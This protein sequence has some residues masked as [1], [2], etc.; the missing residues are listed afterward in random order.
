MGRALSQEL[1]NSPLR[2]KHHEKDRSQ[3]HPGRIDLVRVRLRPYPSQSRYRTIAD[4]LAEPL[5]G[6]IGLFAVS[7]WFNLATHMYA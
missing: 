3:A 7:G 2:R 1:P 6:A 4:V 5:F